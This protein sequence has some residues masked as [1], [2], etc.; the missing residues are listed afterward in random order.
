MYITKSRGVMKLFALAPGSLF[1]FRECVHVKTSEEDSES[2]CVCY[3]LTDGSRFGGGL[4]KTELDNLNVT[5][6]VISNT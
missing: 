3:R 6:V 1:I 5:H 2:R 4:T